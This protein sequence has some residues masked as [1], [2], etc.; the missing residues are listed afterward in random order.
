MFAD[1]ALIYIVYPPILAA[2][3]CRKLLWNK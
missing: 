3:G 1:M 2:S